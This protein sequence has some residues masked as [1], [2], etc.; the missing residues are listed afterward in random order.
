LKEWIDQLRAK[1]RVPLLKIL[2]HVPDRTSWRKAERRFIARYQEDGFHLFNA[3]VGGQGP[4]PEALKAAWADPESRRRRMKA[5]HA[6]EVKAKMSAAQTEINNRP[7]MKERKSIASALSNGTPEQRALF[8]AQQTERMKK[9]K[10]RKA[11]SNATKAR[12]EDPTYKE[13]TMKAMQT[14]AQSSWSDPIKA[15][16]RRAKLAATWAAKRV[17]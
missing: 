4:S 15:A 6:P 11:V 8:S 7:G 12:W 3:T 16:E 2:F 1:G 9:R 14:A 5:I 13:Q 17:T 10:Y